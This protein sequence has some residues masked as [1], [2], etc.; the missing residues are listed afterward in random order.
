MDYVVGNPPYVRVHNLRE[1]YEDI[2]AFSFSKK[3]MTDLFI[4][5]FEIGFKMLN[6]T[7]KMSYI[8]PTS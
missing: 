2:K 3:G 5:F 4:V 7:G 6:K 8:S 1:N